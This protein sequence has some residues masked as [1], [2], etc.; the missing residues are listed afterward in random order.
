MLHKIFQATAIILL[1]ATLLPAQKSDAFQTAMYMEQWQKAVTV[2]EA[3]AN[4]T[5]TDWLA[6]LYLSDAYNAANRPM[7]AQT[8]LQNAAKH[9]TVATDQYIINGRLALLA[10]HYDEAVEQFKKAAKSGKKEVAALRLIGESWLYGPKSEF[11]RAETQLLAAQHRDSR[12]FQTLMDL[13]YCYKMLSDG[14]KALVQYDLAQA[15]A[16]D[17]PLPALMSAMAYKSAKVEPKQLEY[18]NKALSLDPRYPQALRQKA[19]LFYYQKRDYPAAA[20]VYAQL[21][22]INPKAPIAD[23]MA[24]VNCLFLTKQYEPTIAWVEKIISEDG[25]RNYLRRLSAYAHYETNLFAE[26]KTIMDTY[27]KQVKS[28][29]IIPQDYEYYAKFLQQ[30]RQDSLAA[31]YFEKAIELDPARWDLYNEIGSIRYKSKDYLGAAEAYEHRLDSLTR[32]TALDYYQIGLARYMLRDSANYVLAAAY[33][34]K[35]SEIVPDKTIGWMMQAK[36]LSKLEPDVETYPERVGEFGKAKEA[37]EHFVAIAALQPDKHKKD[38]I[39]AY[40]YLSYYY[41]LQKEAAQVRAYQEHLLMLDPTNETAVGIA[42]WLETAA[43]ED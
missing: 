6:W 7:D 2:Q 23:K 13:G 34:A 41:I 17:N 1:F 42:G 26:G 14:G 27:F 37:F 5:S 10:G 21:F 3:R 35:V 22:E 31:I 9:S 29:K 8:A 24:Y 12:D 15:L 19:E 30:E 39:S 36:V 18:L 4:A 33:F 28:E 20:L 40:E 25:S 38:L 11:H 32:R 16:P 43:N